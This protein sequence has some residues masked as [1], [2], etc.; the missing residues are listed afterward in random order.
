MV[1]TFRGPMRSCMRPAGTM[2]RQNT[3]QAMA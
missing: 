2:T 1:A 3:R